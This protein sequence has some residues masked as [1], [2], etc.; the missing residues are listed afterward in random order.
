[1]WLGSCLPSCTFNSASWGP[2]GQRLPPTPHWIPAS[3]LSVWRSPPW[4]PVHAATLLP[5][6]SRISPSAPS[7]KEI[8]LVQFVQNV[9]TW[10]GPKSSAWPLPVFSNLIF[11]FSPTYPNSMF[12]PCHGLCPWSEYAVNIHLCASTWNLMPRERPH[13]SK[14]SANKNHSTEL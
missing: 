9:V 7:Q 2:L 8:Q 14:T 4:T 11:Y 10:K 1:M 13:F 12:T 5:S 3:N 6:S